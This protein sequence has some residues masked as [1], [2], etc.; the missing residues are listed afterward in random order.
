MTRLRAK[1]D[2]R[3]FPGMIK[4]GDELVIQ[5]ETR[6]EFVLAHFSRLLEGVEEEPERPAAAGKRGGK[7][8]PLARDRMAE[9]TQTS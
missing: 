4:K 7:S 3:N 5:D 9:P 1:K 6:A 8:R 2:F